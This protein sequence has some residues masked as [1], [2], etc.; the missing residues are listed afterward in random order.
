MMKIYLFARISIDYTTPSEEIKI[1]I[2]FNFFIVVF[3]FFQYT[4]NHEIFIINIF[5]PLLMY[6]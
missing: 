1:K 4:T 6:I 5:L 2:N 3:R